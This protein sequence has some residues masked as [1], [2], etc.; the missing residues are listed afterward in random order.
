MMSRPSF[1][2]SSD[3]RRYLRTLGIALGVLVGGLVAITATGY[4]LGLVEAANHEI[5]RYQRAKI[6]APEDIDI[7]FVGDSSLG[8][9]IDAALFSSLSGHRTV[10]LAL[11]GSYGAGGSYN[12]ARLVLQRHTPRLI[13]V[14]Q[15]IDVMRREAAFAGFYFS[16]EPTQLLTASPVSML[17]LYFSLK[18]ARRV[19][20][21]IR[22]GGFTQD[23]VSFDSDYIRQGRRLT[24]PVE[25]VATNPL[26][27]DMI[28][29]AQLD[30]VARIAT[31]CSRHDTACVFAF[32]PIFDGY[33]IE[34]TDYITKLSADIRTAGLAVVAGTPL[35]ITA[36]Q[37]GDSV[38]HVRPGLKQ[39]STRRYFALLRHAITSA[40]A[41]R[42]DRVTPRNDG[43]VPHKEPRGTPQSLR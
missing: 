17:E 29:Q 2:S 5:Y 37:L 21:Q 41:P 1:T 9:A 31:L 27:P 34:A 10:N 28:A 43:A 30:Y 35:C 42:P 8:N 25:E 32:G 33:C 24:N 6:V 18:T 36:S 14:M 13:V 7:A 38:D 23:P 16:A 39:D 26:L 15:S 11:N 3:A 12:M 4:H 19:V 40:Y 22:K 20:D